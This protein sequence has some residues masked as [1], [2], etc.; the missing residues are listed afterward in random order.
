MTLLSGRSVVVTGA[1][2]GLGRAYA[3]ACA[4]HGADVVV[5]DVDE[6]GAYDCAREIVAAGGRAVHIAG[7]VASW[8][9]AAEMVEIA[10]RRFGRLDGLVANAG[11]IHNALPWDEDEASLRRIVEVNV[12]GVLF[13]ATHAM[14]AMVR[15]GTGGSIV[16]VVSGARFGIEGM[17]TY[18]AT[19]GA[20]AAM[21]AAWAHEGAAV[22]IRVNAISPLA[23]TDMAAYDHRADP[24]PLGSPEDVAP[25]VVALLS[26]ATAGL[27]GRIIRFDGVTLSRYEPERLTVIGEPPGPDRAGTVWRAAPEAIARILMQPDS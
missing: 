3:L 24:P 11:I 9:V 2:K 12:L 4:A 10:L 25:A 26:D 27:T 6:Q 5:N 1:G 18:G 7:S 20:V 22:G 21:T 13:C 14:R 8:D 16:T 19:K 23:A 17:S 15:Q